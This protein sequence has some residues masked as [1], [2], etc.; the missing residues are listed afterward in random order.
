MTDKE[1][2]ELAKNIRKYSKWL[3][4]EP[5]AK[6]RCRKFLIKTGIYNNKGELTEHYK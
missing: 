4:R 3:C 6:E 2:D 5:G 1:I